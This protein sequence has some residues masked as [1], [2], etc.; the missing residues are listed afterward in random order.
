[1]YGAIAG[2][3]QSSILESNVHLKFEGEIAQ[4]TNITYQ[5]GAI[6][7]D[8]TQVSLMVRDPEKYLRDYKV[9]TSSRRPYYD[10][11]QNFAIN[12]KNYHFQAAQVWLM[13][14]GD[15]DSHPSQPGNEYS[16]GGGVGNG[17][18][19]FVW[20]RD[21]LKL[22]W[23]SFPSSSYTGF[24]TVS[25]TAGPSFTNT[26][27][28]KFE[29]LDHA[30][31]NRQSGEFTNLIKSS[32]SAASA[33]TLS[34]WFKPGNNNHENQNIFNAF[35]QYNTMEGTSIIRV[36]YNGN[37]GSTRNIR[38]NV[39]DQSGGLDKDNFRLDLS[40]PVGDVTHTNG[41]NGFHH[42]AITCGGSANA[43]TSASLGIKIY[44][45]GVLQ[46][47]TDNSNGG[48]IEDVPPGGETFSIAPNKI[49]VGRQP[50]NA[51]YMRDS[52]VDELSFF[53]KELSASEV[54]SLYNGGSPS[55]L[56]IFTPGP[57]H[58]YRMGDGDSGTTL[59]DSIGNADLT[60]NNMSESNFV[61]DVP[62]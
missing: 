52:K 27:S 33:Y 17:I 41:S 25:V 31:K 23:S 46:T 20:P 40:T 5:Q 36:M 57:A 21:Y 42:I 58:W 13:G 8:D 62:S 19:N 37:T 2:T 30:T 7:L 11:T 54:A 44:I 28:T 26:R 1:M 32:G 34:F 60:M 9:G 6:L 10:T 61:T 35:S 49:A 29:N 48:G 22:D 16:G 59:A 38:F 47:L 3:N 18:Q 55:N 50:T 4:A 24:T 51:N 15:Y 53:N 39:F 14:D 43:Y 56:A 45:N 12:M